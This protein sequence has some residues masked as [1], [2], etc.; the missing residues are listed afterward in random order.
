MCVRLAECINSGSDKIVTH[1]FSNV[2]SVFWYTQK[3]VID[4]NRLIYEQSS[5][6]LLGHYQKIIASVSNINTIIFLLVL[7]FNGLYY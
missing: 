6:R 5:L 2:H 4:V 7:K 1:L 3:L